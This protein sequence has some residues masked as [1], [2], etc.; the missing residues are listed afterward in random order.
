VCAKSLKVMKNSLLTFLIT[1]NTDEAT[2]VEPKNDIINKKNR[3]LKLCD[4]VYLN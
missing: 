1:D 3:G 2:S 4:C